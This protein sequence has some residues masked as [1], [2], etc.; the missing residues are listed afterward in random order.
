MLWIDRCPALQAGPAR[1]PTHSPA[2]SPAHIQAPCPSPQPCPRHSPQSC[3]KPRSQ[4][5]PRRTQSPATAQ[6]TALPPAQPTA[7]A[8][9][10]QSG[11]QATAKFVLLAWPWAVVRAVRWPGGRD[12]DGA[13]LFIYFRVVVVVVGDARRGAGGAGR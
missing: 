6:A 3:P 1:S 7:S 10:S 8:R 4:S 5:G 9:F 11:P 2:R 13:H 12:V